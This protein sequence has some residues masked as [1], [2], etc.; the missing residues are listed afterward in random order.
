MCPC[1]RNTKKLY[2]IATEDGGEARLKETIAELCG[3]DVTTDIPAAPAAEQKLA[4]INTNPEAAITANGAP[5]ALAETPSSESGTPTSR[6]RRRKKK[7]RWGTV[8]K[9]EQ[10]AGEE[11]E[12]KKK[13]RKSRWSAEGDKV[14]I[15]QGCGGVGLSQTQAQT[16]IIRV[17]LQEVDSKLLTVTTDAVAR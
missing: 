8:S 1:V 16:M 14:A 17:K 2:L 5:G 3:T 7:S 4:D 11:G 13:R 15:V 6:E 12:V 10:G 9:D